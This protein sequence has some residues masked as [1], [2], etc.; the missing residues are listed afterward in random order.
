MPK[1]KTYCLFCSHTLEDEKQ[2]LVECIVNKT[3]RDI[4]VLEGRTLISKL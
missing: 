3:E 4:L 1:D 2:F